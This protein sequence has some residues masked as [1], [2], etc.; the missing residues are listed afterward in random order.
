MAQRQSRRRFVRTAGVGLLGFCV[1]GCRRD[2]T[3]AQAREQA[4][5]YSVLDPEQVRT[6]EAFGETLL[7]GSAAGGLT[8]FVDHQLAAPAGEQMLMIKYLG[9]EPPFEPFYAGGLQALN[10]LAL[11]AH[12][13][14]FHGLS[15]E[16]RTSLVPEIARGNPEGWDGPPAPL[17]YFVVR[18]DALD[19]MYGTMQGV[20]SLGL[21]YMAHIEP[22]SRWGE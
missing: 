15:T 14:P 2:L 3:P 9:V 19:V 16:Q 1:G 4:V 12:D 8:H 11:S 13:A 18:S 21:P 22:P 17:F 6:L 10:A 7:P 5:P 20:E